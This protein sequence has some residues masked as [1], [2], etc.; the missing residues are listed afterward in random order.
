MLDGSERPTDRQEGYHEE[1]MGLHRSPDRDMDA[2]DLERDGNRAHMDA[3]DPNRAHSATLIPADQIANR[4][5]LIPPAADQIA[6][7]PCHKLLRI[8]GACPLFMD[9][10]CSTYETMVLVMSISIPLTFCSPKVM[11]TMP[12]SNVSQL[13]N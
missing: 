3:P 11:S 13:Q 10:T 2:A 6:N 7:G 8:A 5:T 12:F 1:Q 9:M 4:A